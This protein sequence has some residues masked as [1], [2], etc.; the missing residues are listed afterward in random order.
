MQKVITVSSYASFDTNAKFIE[1]EYPI[2]NNY[3]QDGYKVIQVVPVIK[4]A[5]TT[6]FH[7][8]IFVLEKI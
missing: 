5:N 1:T 8:T 7:E 4:P 6:N 2:L 3:L